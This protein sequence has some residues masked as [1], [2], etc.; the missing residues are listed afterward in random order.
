MRIWQLIE[1]MNF[2]DNENGMG[3]APFNRDVS[4]FG[5]SVKMKPSTFLKLALPISR[6]DASTAD[7][8]KDFLSKGGKIGSPFFQ[9][10]IPEGWETE[11]FSAPAKVKSHEGRNRMYAIKELYG[12]TPVEVHLFFT[13]GLRARNITQEWR[14]ELAKGILSEDGSRIIKDVF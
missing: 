2:I 6:K 11:D 4:Y 14:D 10:Q 9:I 5:L 7:G 1:D 3:A 8:L 12:D 13:G